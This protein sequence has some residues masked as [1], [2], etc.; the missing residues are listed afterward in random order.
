MLALEYTNQIKR[1]LKLAKKRG[2]NLKKLGTVTD[3]LQAEKP[4]PEKYRNHKLSGEY[5]D[6]WECH[7]E[8]DWL[9]IYLLFAHAIKLVRTGT[10]ADLFE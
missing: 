10:H 8:G 2:K 3:L 4:L 5:K 6:H 9:L 7:I 1:D